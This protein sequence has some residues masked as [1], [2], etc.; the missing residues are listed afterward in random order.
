ML[1]AY[2]IRKIPHVNH[3]LMIRKQNAP[4][5]ENHLIRSGYSA[6]HVKTGHMRCAFVVYT[7]ETTLIG[8][9]SDVAQS[10]H[11]SNFVA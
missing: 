10:G 2:R 3:V 4:F 6:I 1:R 5:V 7:A 11:G 8:L 9:I